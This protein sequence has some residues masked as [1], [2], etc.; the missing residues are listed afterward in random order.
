MFTL[1]LSLNLKAARLHEQV[2]QFVVPVVGGM[3]L[4]KS[5]EPHIDFLFRQTKQSITK[6]ASFAAN[7]VVFYGSYEHLNSRN[8][9]A[10]TVS[11]LLMVISGVSILDSSFKFFACNALSDIK[12]WERL[13]WL[14]EPRS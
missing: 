4:Q 5:L 9:L 12:P 13:M 11:I 7:G 14:L 10:N 1:V 2:I 8:K 3:I 6:L